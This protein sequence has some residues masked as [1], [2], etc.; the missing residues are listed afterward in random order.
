MPQNSPA[1]GTHRWPL[2]LYLQ[3]LLLREQGG[4]DGTDM[5]RE[6][7]ILKE[8][9]LAQAQG[10]QLFEVLVVKFPEFLGISRCS[11]G[12]PD[13]L[14]SGVGGKHRVLSWR[15]NTGTAINFQTQS[16]ASGVCGITPRPPTRRTVEQQLAKLRAATVTKSLLA[17]NAWGKSWCQ[18]PTGLS[19]TSAVSATNSIWNLP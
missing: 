2:P 8:L 7:G 11:C 13:L 17:G 9:P 12:L 15:G 5:S 19:Q 18:L 3:E 14:W 1:G 16:G 6:G 4:A 10:S